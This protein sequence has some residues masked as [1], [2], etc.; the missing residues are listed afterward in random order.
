MWHHSDSGC[1]TVQ[2]GYH[3]AVSLDSRDDHSSS[4]TN[5]K[6]WNRLWSLQLPKKVKIFAWRLVNDALPSVINLAHRK[7]ASSVLV[8]FANVAG[9]RTDMPSSLSRA[10][11]VWDKFH[12][13][14]FIPNIANIKGFSAILEIIMA[15][16]FF[17][18]SS[19]STGPFLL[20]K[21]RFFALF[22]SLDWALQLHLPISF[23][24]TDALV[25]VNALNKASSTKFLAPFYDLVEDV[26]YLLSFFPRV[27]VSHVK[28]MLMKRLIFS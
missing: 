2:S 6:W 28:E 23:I 7:I 5:R 14:V 1:Y 3:L 24:E 27:K 9:N 26:S 25:V 18:L 20:K 11:L 8:L 21:W 16:L 19:L 4:S 10:K 17:G 13:N 22:H 15:L 12:F